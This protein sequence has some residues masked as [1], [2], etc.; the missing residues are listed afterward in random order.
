MNYE[1][2]F[3]AAESRREKNGFTRIDDT[4]PVDMFIGL[5]NGERAVMTVCSQRPPE[6]PSLAAIGVEVRL[7]QDG[8][9][10]LVLRLLRP[11]LKALFNRL[12][13][14]LD[15]AM[16]QQPEN[17]GETVVARLARWQRLFSQ[18]P[19]KLLGDQELRGLC[20][21][22]DFLLTEAIRVVGRRAAVIAWE[23]PRGA[24]KDFVFD[25]A[26]VEVK[27]V[28]QQPREYCISS[29]EQLT[30][31]GKPLFLWARVVELG[32]ARDPSPSSVAGLVEK[33][34]AATAMD[35][36]ASEELEIRL[37]LAGYEDRSEYA[38]RLVT[39]GPG[40][41]Y[42]VAP[43][44]PR[45]ERPAVATGIVSCQ[46]NIQAAALEA[47]R[48]GSWQEGFRDGRRRT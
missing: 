12:I 27:A 2:K 15:G 36:A 46:Y 22:L 29:L 42:K 13:E 7:R 40:T 33:L 23:G 34:R 17:P 37:S 31:L 6:P 8:K 45:I 16:R 43:G 5:E 10:A 48:V 18:R 41:C 4:H 14:D 30:D 21:E 39:F 26:E 44:F 35:P 38:L 11:E 3:C 28:H 1:E 47:F 20:A 9:W 32:H 24:P 25:C 19:L